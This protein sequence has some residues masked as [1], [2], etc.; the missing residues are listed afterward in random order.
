MKPFKLTLLSLV[1]IST[2]F[3]SCGPP[4][5]LEYRE[6]RNFT[7]DKLGFSSSSVKMDLVYFNPNNYGLQLKRTDLDI[8][9]N[10]VLLGH[11]S[12][13]Y[14]ITIPRKEEFSIPIQI[15]VDMQNLLRNSISIMAKKQVMVKLIGSV[16]VGKANVFIS[17][18]V[19]FQEQ[20]TF[21]L[22]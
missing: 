8:Y 15:D 13:E 1:L 5:A 7:V 19:N 12:Q 17:F 20:E 6:F 3:I 21:I 4:K 9:I 22:F 11:T 18:P 14:Q 16:K 2:L 10:D